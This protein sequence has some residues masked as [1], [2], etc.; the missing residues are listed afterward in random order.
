MMAHV[1]EASEASGKVLLLIEEGTGGIE[2]AAQAAARFASAFDAEI[3]SVGINQDSAERAS[4]LET[5]ALIRL[6]PRNGTAPRGFG[7]IADVQTLIALRQHRAIER[8]TRRHNVPCRHTPLAGNVVDRLS[9]VCVSRGPWNIVVLSAP[10]TPATASTISAIFAN[11]SGATGIV[12]APPRIAHEDGPIAIV[13]EDAD[14]LPAMLRAASRLKSLCGRVHLLLAAN[15]RA[16]LDA[17]ESHVRLATSKHIGL[18]IEPPEPLYGVEGVLDERLRQLRASF[19]VARF[20]GALLPTHRALSRTI[21]FSAAP[22]LL[23][24]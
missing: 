15:K 13:V 4:E 1:A 20:A 23:V 17:L 10:A 7:R 11:V 16:D 9:E 14:R 21:A 18:V 3:E 6:R 12:V 19:V 2:V 24:R 8:A 22:F 5:A